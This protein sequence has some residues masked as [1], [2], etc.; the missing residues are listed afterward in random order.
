MDLTFHERRDLQGLES[1]LLPHGATRQHVRFAAR[2]GG[3]PH[4]S[5]RPVKLDLLQ[6][7]IVIHFLSCYWAIDTGFSFRVCL[8]GRNIAETPR[9]LLDGGLYK[10]SMKPPNLGRSSCRSSRVSG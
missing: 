4:T 2:R 5:C 6:V 8:D 3:L 1:P 10:P 9:R 7:A